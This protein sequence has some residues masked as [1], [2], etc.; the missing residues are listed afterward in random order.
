[1]KHSVREP[2]LSSHARCQPVPRCEL[3]EPARAGGRSHAYP[4]DC[5][6]DARDWPDTE[7]FI[8]RTPGPADPR[9]RFVTVSAHSV[10][11]IGAL[12]ALPDIGSKPSHEKV[13]ARREQSPHSFKAA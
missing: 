13:S 3:D 7:A 12:W 9:V 11:S 8:A 6:S 5:R 1:M 4:L 2:S 10:H